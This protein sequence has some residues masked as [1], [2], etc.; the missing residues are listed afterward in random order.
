MLLHKNLFTT[1]CIPFLLS[2]AIPQHI[3]ATQPTYPAHHFGNKTAKLE[4]LEHCITQALQN[5]QGKIHI[6]VPRFI[7]CANTHVYAF[8]HRQGLSLAQE[9]EY[10]IQTEN[11]TA[12]NLFK[13]K[14][15]SPQFFEKL[16]ALQN[17]IKQCCATPY[18]FNRED[19][20]FFDHAQAHQ[21]TLMVR[22]TG[23]EDS[24]TM[25]NAGGNESIANV[26]PTSNA[27]TAA[28]GDVI[29]SYISKKSLQQ[30][31]C[32]A[33][34]IK[35]VQALL[36]PPFIPVLIQEMIGETTPS[37]TTSHDAYIKT[38]PV[39]GVMFT[40]DT[41]STIPGMTLI[42]TTFGH[43]QGVVNSQ[44]PVDSWYISPTNQIRSVVT[45]KTTRLA[46]SPNGLIHVNNITPYGQDFSHYQTLTNEQALA[47]KYI[48]NAIEAT[49]TIPMD[50]EFV[51]MPSHNCIYL[52]QA[53]PLVQQNLQRTTLD[54]AWLDQ[55]P[56]DTFLTCNVIS[57]GKAQ[58]IIISQRN[59][60]LYTKTLAQAL[61]QVL[62]LSAQEQAT[63]KA[64]IVN[65]LPASTS[66]EAT[67]FRALQ[68]P[69]LYHQD[70][71]VVQAW[72]A[73]QHAAQNFLLDPQRGL[74]IPCSQEQ[75]EHL[76]DVIIPG[77]VTSP[78]EPTSVAS[79]SVA[80][81][82]VPPQTHTNILFTYSLF[83]AVR[84]IWSTTLS[85]LSKQAHTSLNDLL[86]EH[87]DP[88]VL[89][90]L[91]TNYL[92]SKLATLASTKHSSYI[93]NE[94]SRIKKTHKILSP[95][96][97]YLHRLTTYDL[98][99]FMHSKNFENHW[100]FFSTTLLHPC[101][102]K[103]HNTL[104]T[105]SD[106]HALIKLY[107]L[108]CMNLLVECFDNAIKTVSGS[109]YY[110]KQQKTSSIHTM[111]TAY[112]NLFETWL[113]WMPQGV[114]QQARETFSKNRTPNLTTAMLTQADIKQ[115]LAFFSPYI[116]NKKFTE[117]DLLPT[118]SFSVMAAILGSGGRYDQL[119]PDAMS[120][121]DYFTLTHQNL[122]SLI[123]ILT[124]RI[125]P[126]DETVIPKHVTQILTLFSKP[127]SFQKSNN[128]ECSVEKGYS[129]FNALLIAVE[130][131]HETCSWIYNIPLRGHSSRFIVHYHKKTEEV[132]LECIF[133]RDAARKWI[134]DRVCAYLGT[135]YPSLGARL[136]AMHTK[137]NA[138]TIKLALA[139]DTNV[140]KLT[141]II[142]R[143]IILL[144]RESTFITIPKNEL[145]TFEQ[146]QN[147]LAPELFAEWSHHYALFYH[148][149]LQPDKRDKLATTS[150]IKN[151]IKRAQVVYAKQCLDELYLD[152][153]KIINL[154][155][156]HPLFIEAYTTYLAENPPTLANHTFYTKF[157]YHLVNHMTESKNNTPFLQ[158]Y[159]AT[160]LL[161]HYCNFCAAIKENTLPLNDITTWLLELFHILQQHNQWDASDP[162]SIEY[163]ILSLIIKHKE[164]LEPSTEPAITLLQKIVVTSLKNQTI[165]NSPIPPYQ[166]LCNYLISHG[167]SMPFAQEF[168]Q[169]ASY[170]KERLNNP[171][172]CNKTYLE[173]I[174][175]TLKKDPT[176]Q[177]FV[178]V[179]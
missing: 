108:R 112:W 25:A 130:M 156:H 50:I 144:F 89:S 133:F 28:M 76:N 79:T 71:R 129:Q 8:L 32:C 111:V 59:A 65:T 7:G 147:T 24:S 58:P 158:L 143:A 15:F 104:L 105:S 55:Q 148:D 16:S 160:L 64:V 60:I 127:L 34:T 61:D 96:Q 87:N 29:A 78:L 69:V 56:H 103:E 123:T 163:S 70:Q 45:Q 75:A 145:L 139:Q 49:Y 13:T 100:N 94:C 155:Q 73:A 107:A 97:D 159:N 81:T 115:Y 153:H 135:V 93:I 175:E 37:S 67:T 51:L 63:I 164:R 177:A 38:I 168:A 31:L 172:D 23:A 171:W 10:L 176:L 1:L 14:Q 118:P 162:E 74:F 174:I 30:R 154:M 138:A 86:S 99:P 57:T 149:S 113:S 125:N 131:N 47:L 98:T 116:K 18:P 35:D 41:E 11:I 84:T 5:P 33:T 152:Q 68:I 66:H 9:W 161:Y 122:L 140:E 110:T 2:C 82:S 134:F 72:R 39:S 40:T 106:R 53:R 126:I 95:L 157:F 54:P 151:N 150:D 173:T 26:T 178:K 142:T 121:E 21:S 169:H 90:F 48:A 91:I 109:P 117:V 141:A 83:P 27:I 22:S 88:T 62:E 44:V 17:R 20:S 43:N 137:D 52:V 4:Q 170:F 85:H 120:L 132:E 6:K 102:K 80:P 167:K 146:A 165:F 114:F 136:V 119:T 46:P 92:P 128:E 77:G 179:F 3:M 12:E 19:L 42:Q 166:E 101:T 36:A 124:Q